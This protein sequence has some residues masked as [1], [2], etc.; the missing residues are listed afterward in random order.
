ML[1]Y[2]DVLAAPAG[3]KVMLNRPDGTITIGR[4]RCSLNLPARSSRS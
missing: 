1:A 2:L 3:H 4:W